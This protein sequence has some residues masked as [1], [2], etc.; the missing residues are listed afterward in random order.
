MK[1]LYWYVLPTL[2]SV[3]ITIAACGSRSRT[4]DTDAN[5]TEHGRNHCV[6][7]TG[8]DTDTRIGGRRRLRACTVRE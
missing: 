4:T 7:H 6:K 3:I 8:A 5:H 2:L 1:H